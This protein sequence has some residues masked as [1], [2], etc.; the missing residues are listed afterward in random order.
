MPR[1]VT[2]TMLLPCTQK[3]VSSSKA[4]KMFSVRAPPF[5]SPRLALALPHPTAFPLSHYP[6]QSQRQQGSSHASRAAAAVS[7]G[8]G[9]RSAGYVQSSGY[10]YQN[11]SSSSSAMKRSSSSNM[12]R[13]SSYATR[14]AAANA[15]SSSSAQQQ[16]GYSRSGGLMLSQ[17]SSVATSHTC[18]LSSCSSRPGVIYCPPDGTPPAP[19]LNTSTQH[20]RSCCSHKRFRVCVL[21]VCS[22]PNCHGMLKCICHIC[23]CGQHKCPVH[24]RRKVQR[25]KG[26]SEA[27]AEYT[28]KEA[29]VRTPMNTMSSQD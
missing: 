11:A 6:R 27:Q 28:R 7:R 17:R 13:S 8:G 2:H 18:S 15:S 10:G 23:N 4:Q 1:S 26:M 16:M 3:I 14:T 21:C 9:R 12:V 24:D 20:K 25:F 29:E 22:D 19:S 5:P